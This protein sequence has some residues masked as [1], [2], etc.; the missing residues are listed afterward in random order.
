[1]L[2]PNSGYTDNEETV[3]DHWEMRGN[4]VYAGKTYKAGGKLYCTELLSMGFQRLYEN[5]VLFAKRDPEY[6]NFVMRIA[7]G[8]KG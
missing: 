3:E 1:M 4:S 8:K 7:Q 6:F 5:P 2:F